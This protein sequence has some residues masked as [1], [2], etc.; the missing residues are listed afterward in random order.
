[1]RNKLRKE[2]LTTNDN[3]D[4]DLENW[5]RKPNQKARGK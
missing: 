3:L 5:G 2:M 4:I 1:M